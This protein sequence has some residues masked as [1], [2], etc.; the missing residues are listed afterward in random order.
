MNNHILPLLAVCAVAAC[1]GNPLPTGGGGG[2]GGG[3]VAPPGL[4]VPEVIRQNLY[5]ATFDA[6]N[7]TLVVDMRSLDG[8]PIQLNYV[9]DPALDAGGYMAFSTQDTTSQRKFVAMF[10]RTPSGTIQG[11]TAADGGQFV[12]Y[13]GGGSYGRLGVFTLPTS[14]LASYAGEYVGLINTGFA[15]TPG[16][17]GALNPRQSYRVTGRML[18]NADFNANNMQVNGGVD[19]RRIVEA[20]TMTDA[21]FQ[22]LPANDTGMPAN[23]PPIFLEVTGIESNGTFENVVKLNPQQTVGDYSGMFGGRDASDVAGAMVFR[24]LSGTQPIEHGA[25]V[26]PRCVGGSPS[27][28]P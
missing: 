20:G 19:Q 18:L 10:K 15:T 16:P 8:T 13:F 6:E 1:S 22:A 28:C 12:N 27:P 7:Q 26:L 4:E 24:P 17:G 11:G 3:G 5:G 14:G 21:E 25:F 23:L 9:R 2:G